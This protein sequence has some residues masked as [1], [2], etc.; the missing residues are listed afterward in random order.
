[1]LSP[2]AC[3]FPLIGKLKPK[4][5]LELHVWPWPKKQKAESAF[6]RGVHSFRF[7]LAFLM[8][9]FPADVVAS[10]WVDTL[11]FLHQFKQEA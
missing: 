3:S 5:F 1:M 9:P 7:V 4:L 11:Q 6:T 10:F 2:M 8:N